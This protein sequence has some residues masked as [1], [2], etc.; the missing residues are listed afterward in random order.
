MHL[1]SNQLWPGRGR[2]SRT[3][4]WQE[5]PYKDWGGGTDC[6]EGSCVINE[7]VSQKVLL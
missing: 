6:R 5:H 4:G 3:T 1:F 2:V 7:E